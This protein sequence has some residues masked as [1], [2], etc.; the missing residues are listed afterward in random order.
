MDATISVI[1]FKSK[2]LANGEHPLMLRITKDRKRTMKSLGVS[3]H[4][5][6]WDFDR[7]EP[8][9][10]CPDRKYIQQNFRSSS[11]TITPTSFLS[12]EDKT[13]SLNVFNSF[14]GREMPATELFLYERFSR[15]VFI[16]GG[17]LQ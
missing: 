1:C 5:S 4:P 9:P 7:N 10:K 17:F 8:K 14:S 13:T 6:N 11:A 12:P 16:A 15:I 3:V 2:T